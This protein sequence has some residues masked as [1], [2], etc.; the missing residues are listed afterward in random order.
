MFETGVAVKTAVLKI[1]RTV[2]TILK[3]AVFGGS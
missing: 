1:N 3:T 2:L